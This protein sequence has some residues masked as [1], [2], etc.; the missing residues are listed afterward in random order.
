MH[1]YSGSLQQGEESLELAV[2]HALVR[3][4]SDGYLDEALRIYRPAAPVV[5]FGRRDTRLPGFAAAVQAARDAGFEPLVR[6]VGG[7]PVAYTTEALVVDHVRHERLA[8]DGMEARFIQY[9]DLYAG[10]L[11]DLGIDAR[12]GAVPGEYCPGAH[13]VNARGVV[14]LI[15]TGQRVVRDGWLFSALIVLGDDE[16]LRPLLTEV[17]R[18][19]E[20]PFDPASVGSIASEAAGRGESVE[21]RLRAAYAQHAVLEPAVL[22][23]A[24][25]AV[26]H[27]LSADHRA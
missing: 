24:T 26:A 8:P 14:K 4:A 6:A 2:A 17:Y 22:D 15:G 19:L 9:G 25:L 3:R 20:L 23:A 1:V 13:S 11:R 12:V 7:R 5:V 21:L 18:L 27:E 16:L 10:V